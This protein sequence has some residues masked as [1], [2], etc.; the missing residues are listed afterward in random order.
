MLIEISDN[1]NTNQLFGLGL[2]WLRSG[3]CEFTKLYPD[4]FKSCLTELTRKR[5]L[6]RLISRNEKS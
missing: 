3:L 5:F 6:R 4:V 2:V 1:Q